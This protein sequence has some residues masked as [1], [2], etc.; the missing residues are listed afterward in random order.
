MAMMEDIKDAVCKD[1]LSI[2]L[3]ERS[4]PGQELIAFVGVAECK[5]RC[6]RNLLRHLRVNKERF[7]TRINQK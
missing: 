5:D 6:E 1:E 2:F 3:T 4:A 7:L